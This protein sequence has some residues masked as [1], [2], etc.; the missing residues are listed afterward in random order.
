VAEGD[1]G[2]VIVTSSFTHSASCAMPGFPGA[3]KSFPPLRTA[4][5][6]ASFH[7]SACSRPPEPRRRM[8]MPAYP[9]YADD[10]GPGGLVAKQAP[11]DNAGAL[12]HRDF[13]LLKRTVEDRFGFVRVRGELSG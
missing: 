7:A 9:P 1:H 13:A 4:W 10:D 5:D 8:F 2:V 12:H 6:C 3:A 11:G